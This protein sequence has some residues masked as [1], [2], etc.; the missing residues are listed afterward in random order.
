MVY[1]IDNSWIVIVPWSD[2]VGII[3]VQRKVQSGKIKF[4]VSSGRSQSG[5]IKE[6]VLL[7]SEFPIGVIFVLTLVIFFSW[8][9]PTSVILY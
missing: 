6:R 2:M 9:G 4:M 7:F 1:L 5:N 3:S 8:E